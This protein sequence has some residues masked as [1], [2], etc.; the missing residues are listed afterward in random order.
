MN[1]NQEIFKFLCKKYPGRIVKGVGALIM[2]PLHFWEL[3]SDS[4]N[5]NYYRFLFVIEKHRNA[6][7]GSR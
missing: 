7:C 4:Q 6:P 2:N 1:V 5:E 3:Y